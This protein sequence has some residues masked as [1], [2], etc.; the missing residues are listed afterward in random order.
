MGQQ[1]A[2]HFC[3]NMLDSLTGV[4]LHPLLHPLDIPFLPLFGAQALVIRKLNM[5]AIDEPRRDDWVMPKLRDLN[6]SN[7]STK[8]TAPLI[9]APEVSWIVGFNPRPQLST[10]IAE[11]L[12]RRNG[13]GL[14]PLEHANTN[15]RA[16]HRHQVAAH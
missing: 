7:W 12:W 10:F 3:V 14:K 4:V 8:H 15:A 6:L 13:L 16:L 2:G 5:L 1:Q 11:N 9:L